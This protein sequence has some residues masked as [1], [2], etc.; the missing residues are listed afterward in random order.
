MIVVTS[1]IPAIVALSS[2]MSLP[3]EQVGA[4]ASR[5]AEMMNMGFPVPDGWVVTEKAFR[6]FCIHNHISWE[7]VHLLPETIM[8]GSFPAGLEKEIR[9]RLRGP[10]RRRG[11]FAVR[12]SS[13]AEDGLDFSMA[14]QFET[15][16]DVTVQG[17]SHAVKRCWASRYGQA[18]SAYMKKRMSRQ[19]PSMGVIIQEQINPVFSGVLF[20]MNPL[21]RSTDQL[22]VEWVEGLGEKLVSG[23]VV[24]GRIYLDRGS[25]ITGQSV[26]QGLKGHLILLRRFALEAER[27]FSQPV[28]MEWCCDEK[29]LY[30][31]QARPITG[32]S[33][34]DMV[35]WTN[36]NMAE[37]F[38]MVLAPLAWSAVDYF[39]TC[40]MECALKFFG[41]AD[42]LSDIQDILTSL[43]GVHCGRIYYNLNSWYQV[44]YLFP[45]GKWL[46]RFLDT[47]IGQKTTISIS[48]A[49]E[50]T[51]RASPLAR[52]M[53]MLLFWPRLILAISM[54]GR[55]MDVLEDHFHDKRAGWR[56][57]DGDRSGLPAALE[58]MEDL[59]A[60]VKE[61]WQG[62]FC[63]DLKVMVMTGLLEVL[64]GHWINQDTV[65]VMARLMQGIEVK[66]TEPT[67]LIW[68]MAKLIEQD[69]GLLGLLEARDY[70]GLEKALNRQQQVLLHSFMKDFGARCYH[71]C[72]LVHPT[73]EERHD[74]Y[75]DLV[76]RYV[77]AKGASGNWDRDKRESWRIS[78]E[79]HTKALPWWKS[80]VFRKV[81]YLA[82]D[83]TVLRERGRLFQSLL[84]GE[85]RRISLL[86]GR[87]LAEKGHLR[88]EEDV[89]FLQLSEIRD[90]VEGKFQ[91]PETV[92]RLVDIRKEALSRNEELEPPEFFLTPKGEYYMADGYAQDGRPTMGLTG[93][94]VSGGK[95]IGRV[96]IVLDPSSGHGLKDG[97]ILVTR[98]TDP[99]WTPL[100]F[101][102]GGLVLEK[103]GMLSH[104]AIVAREFGIPAIV[105][106]KGATRILKDGQLVEVDG[107]AGTVKV[108]EGEQAGPQK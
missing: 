21:N 29:R 37:N 38:P 106:M 10:D 45:M 26:P 91:F 13:C 15:I 62:P 96:R 72:M 63:A 107:N 44:M 2:S 69:E 52:G 56:S 70:N 17:I 71:D 80:L 88:Q 93:M 57:R 9:Q 35:A 46:A 51:K 43:N 7:D 76:R 79:E 95:R 54:A 85:M 48:P 36:A 39:Y 102:A 92:P 66:S 18:V 24:P 58:I 86:L 73:F 28:D 101:I 75:W 32:I 82:R 84:F 83:A 31:L 68:Q 30:V 108:L 23:Q 81:L 97:D 47:Y 94:G 60:I 104:G 34:P 90:M 40:Y 67:R 14:G 77:G 53:D 11:L 99:G 27:I 16:L 74:L 65:P 78:F 64:I 3:L 41:W 49:K 98:T 22:V 8:E 103:G 55:Y 105:D 6:D 100:F 4:K 87:H 42:R 61:A 59:F 5:L 19:V 50:A 33:N 20:T 89:F 1:S 12:S 25:G